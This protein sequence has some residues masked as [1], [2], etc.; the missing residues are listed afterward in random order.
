M[1]VVVIGAGVAGMAAARTLHH[2]GVEVVVLEAR[3]RLGGRVWTDTSLGIPVDLGASWI[4]GFVPENP[5]A[6]VAEELGVKTCPTPLEQILLRGPGGQ[7]LT[8]VGGWMFSL[9]GLLSM[10]SAEWLREGKKDVPVSACVEEVFETLSV[11]EDLKERLLLWTRATFANYMAAEM[12]EV[13]LKYFDDDEEFPGEHRVFP[14]GAIQL[15]E[16]LAEGL[17][18]RLEHAVS[19]VEYDGDGVRVICAQEVFRADAAIVTLPL[20]V[21]KAGAVTFDPPLPDWKQKAIQRLGMG[22]LDKVIL[23]FP[24]QWWPDEA[25]LAIQP[26]DE[27]PVFSSF[28]SLTHCFD[29]PML[30]TFLG[31]QRARVWTRRPN[32]EIVARAIQDLRTVFGAEQVPDPTDVFVTRW[33]HDIFSRGAYSF[34]PAGGTPE[35][36]EQLAK[37]VNDRLFF[38]GEATI[39]PYY[40]TLHGA[41]VSGLREAERVLALLTDRTAVSV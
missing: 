11:P 26:T 32:E 8:E 6:R 34:V 25:V 7:V 39:R 19:A 20:G 23:R 22:S 3:Q 30:M 9:M 37:P 33:D 36:F 16:R 12:D 27:L 40:G 10:R 13:S 18:V 15:V 2:N 41:Y 5:I 29:E 35:D 21:L 28:I 24:R 38:A 17:D 14:D 31:G 1:R 4:H